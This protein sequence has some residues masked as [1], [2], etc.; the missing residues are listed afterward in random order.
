M[1]NTTGLE[2]ETSFIENAFKTSYDY[3][4]AFA[5]AKRLQTLVLM[6]PGTL[7]NLVDCGLGIRTYLFNFRDSTTINTINSKIQDQVQKYMP[8]NNIQS[9]E[10]EFF[11]DK[12]GSQK[13]IVIKAVLF[14]SSNNELARQIAV[15]FQ[16]PIGF[17]DKII[18]DIYL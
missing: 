12:S 18:S 7:P 5:V 8:N 3:E 17:S 2:I 1:P 10:A 11:V 6:E 15:T 13:S 14:D 9:V 16:K 4:K